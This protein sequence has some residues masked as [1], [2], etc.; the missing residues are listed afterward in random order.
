MNKLKYK[1]LLLCNNT[2]NNCLVT[3]NFIIKFIRSRQTFHSH[4]LLDYLNFPSCGSFYFLNFSTKGIL[5]V[6]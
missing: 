1:D 4:L 3:Q 6:Y 2:P 5:K